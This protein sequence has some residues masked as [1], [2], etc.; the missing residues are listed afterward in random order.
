[1]NFNPKI[2][3]TAGLGDF[4]TV[5]SFLTGHE[6]HAVKE[7]YY[8]ARA[9]YAIDTLIDA[10]PMF[11]NLQKRIVIWDTWTK[12]DEQEEGKVFCIVHK[13]DLVEANM[14]HNWGLN[15]TM[16]ND[17]Q[18][19]S[20]DV[21]FPEIRQGKRTFNTQNIKQLT[22]ADISKFDLPEEYGV[23]S[24]YSPQDRMSGMRDLTKTEWNLIVSNLEKINKYAVV[25]N[26]SDDYIPKHQLIVDLNYKTTPPE[27][28]E[29]AKH[30]KFYIGIDSWITTIVTKHLEHEKM[31]I[32]CNNPH[33]I[34]NFPIY[35]APHNV[36]Y[37]V[38]KSLEHVNWS[39]LL[40]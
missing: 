28:V 7:I 27:A 32:K 34:R 16:L 5:Y 25:I 40:D 17:I 26:R 29:I 3:L 31:I 9:R 24:P 14:K 11:P 22:F 13:H 18:D 12:T 4:I 33:C 6:R 21:F 20:I 35:F 15:L 8:A 2:L 10:A 38:Y 23:I 36:F 37:F 19:L 30:C 39:Y 1:M